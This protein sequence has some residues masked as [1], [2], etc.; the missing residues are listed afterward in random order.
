MRK[1]KR[2][3]LH[4]SQPPCLGSIEIELDG[5]SRGDL[6]FALAGG[7]LRDEVCNWGGG[8]C[9]KTE[10]EAVIVGANTRHSTYGI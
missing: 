6:R 10:L 9:L 4:V 5:A 3:L 7:S 1:K 8:F 2:L